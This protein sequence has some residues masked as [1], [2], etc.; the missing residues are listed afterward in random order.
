M[1]LSSVASVKLGDILRFVFSPFRTFD[2]LSLA[3]TRPIPTAQEAS[4]WWSQSLSLRIYFWDVWIM[5]FDHIHSCPLIRPEYPLLLLVQHFALFVPIKTNLY[6]P[7]IP[8]EYGLV[9]RDCKNCR[10]RSPP[11]PE[12]TNRQYCHS[13]V[14]DCVPNPDLHSEMWLDSEL[15][16]VVTTTVRSYMQLSC[17]VQKI[18]FSLL[19]STASGSYKLSA[20]FLQWSLSLWRRGHGA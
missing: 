8:L 17:C 7:Y 14:W 13:Y 20:P 1:M 4:V 12:A 3:L 2:G 6:C 9:T 5:H 10:K 16:H 11:L 18:L 15:A 19:P